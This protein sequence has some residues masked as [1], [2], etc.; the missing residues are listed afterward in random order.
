MVS[1]Y[2]SLLNEC[3][4]GTDLLSDLSDIIDKGECSIF[5]KKTT[6]NFIE[7]VTSKDLHSKDA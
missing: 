4:G 7:N 6:I 1:L 2:R 3:I 5:K